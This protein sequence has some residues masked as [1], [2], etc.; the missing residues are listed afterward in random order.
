MSSWLSA[1]LLTDK[2]NIA[3]SF[4]YSS[5]YLKLNNLDRRSQNVCLFKVS[6]VVNSSTCACPQC[7]PSWTVAGNALEDDSRVGSERGAVWRYGLHSSEPWLHQREAGF[8]HGKEC[9][10]AV[11]IYNIYSCWY[12]SE[13]VLWFAKLTQNFRLHFRGTE[14]I[15]VNTSSPSLFLGR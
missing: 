2:D 1:S 12:G 8:K 6:S 7:L 4:L 3:F 10:V 11:D 13:E 9:S 5:H 15:V 14:N